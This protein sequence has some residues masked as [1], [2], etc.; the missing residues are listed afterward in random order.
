[1]NVRFL[2]PAEVKIES[3]EA[4]AQGPMYGGLAKAWQA[5]GSPVVKKE[6]ETAATIEETL[7]ISAAG[8]IAAGQDVLVAIC[9]LAKDEAA[10]KV[11]SLGDGVARIRTAE[12]TDYVFASPDGLAL[13]QGDVAF[14]GVAGAVRVYA[15]E[16]HLIVA[17]GA[18][19]V[20]YKG[21][22]LKA[23]QPATKVV[24]MAE[25][26]KGGTL[27]VPAEKVGIAFALD[28]KAGAIEEVAP[29]VRRQK[30]AG[31]M[32]WEFKADRPLRFER[33]GIVF[34]GTRGGLV[35]DGEA[36]TV[37]LVMIEGERIA[38]QGREAKECSGPYDLTFHKDKVVAVA[39]GPARFLMVTQPEGIVQMPC[40]NIG[41][42]RYA[43]GTYD[44]WMI[45]PL[46]GG[47]FE[48]TLE[49]LPQPPVLRSWQ[50]W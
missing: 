42:V 6:H 11:E 46:L 28:E 48:F 37:R 10:P 1:M 39:E 7:T 30:R 32:A 40:V 3:R 24:P 22:T 4:S 26:A 45:V 23:G 5:A 13:K 17:E 49:N 2:Q 41:G 29:G 21:C 38:C 16:V 15:D 43:P 20:S 34:V 36:G 50:E 9:P 31:G 8:P 19:T 14:E 18:G 33:D 47:R 35:T 12:G 27:E 25:V 44:R